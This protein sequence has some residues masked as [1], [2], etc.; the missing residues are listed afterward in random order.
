MQ[1]ALSCVGLAL[2]HADLDAQPILQNEPQQLQ[3]R[4]S[5]TATG[6]LTG[7]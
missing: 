7:Q 3:R 2:F 5:A 1:I 6:S 4:L